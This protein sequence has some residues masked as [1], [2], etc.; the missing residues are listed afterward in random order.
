MLL[1]EELHQAHLVPGILQNIP[2]AIKFDT[3]NLL[4]VA[5]ERPVGN[6]KEVHRVDAEPLFDDADGADLSLVIQVESPE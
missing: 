6:P 5:P 3:L 4:Q 2:E 1:P